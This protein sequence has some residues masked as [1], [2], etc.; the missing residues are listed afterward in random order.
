M[1]IEEPSRAAPGR[2]RARIA[3]GLVAARVRAGK[4]QRQVAGDL[5][6]SVSAVRHYERAR[7]APRLDQ[8]PELAAALA[9]TCCQLLLDMQLIVAACDGA[10]AIVV[11]G[12]TNAPGSVGAL[13]DGSASGGRS[14]VAGRHGDTGRS[15]ESTARTGP[16]PAP[17][18]RTAGSS[19]TEAGNGG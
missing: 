16:G 1:A 10:V 12:T 11:D 13:G 15:P 8:L 17:A 6:L 3:A 7:H 5:S 18:G 14:T 4:S 9:T 19:V 2:V